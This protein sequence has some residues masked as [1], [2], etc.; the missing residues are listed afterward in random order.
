M[1]NGKQDINGLMQIV[2]SLPEGKDIWIR[3]TI[4]PSTLKLLKD[5]NPLVHFMPE[6]LTERTAIDDFAKQKLVF[7][8]NV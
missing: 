6:F 5:I 1:Q 4:L 2:K 7:T 3:T 8:G